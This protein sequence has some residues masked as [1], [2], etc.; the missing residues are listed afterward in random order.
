MSEVSAAGNYPRPVPGGYVMR[1]EIVKNN[2]QKEQLEI[3]LEF[4][5]GDIKDYCKDIKDRFG[6]W[7]ARCTKSYKEK[8]LPFFKSFIEAVQG[9]NADTT[10]LVIGDFED[11]DETKLVGKLVGV[12]VGEKEYDGNDGTRKKALD[13]FNALFVTAEDIKN[14]NF[15]VPELRIT[16]NKATVTPSE[17]VVDYSTGYGPLTEDDIPFA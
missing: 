10:G 15:E 4:P 7:P 8:A 1:I 13:W 16:G 3:C 17:D 5:V 2:P 6:F 9:S 12:V 11:V 14:G